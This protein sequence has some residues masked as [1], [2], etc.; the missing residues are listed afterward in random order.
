MSTVCCQDGACH[1][2]KRSAILCAHFVPS[3]CFTLRMY[4]LLDSQQRNKNNKCRQNFS[5]EKKYVPT[6]YYGA[7]S[8][9]RVSSNLPLKRNPFLFFRIRSM[10]IGHTYH[11][12]LIGA[13]IMFLALTVLLKCLFFV[14]EKTSN[15]CYW[16]FKFVQN[17]I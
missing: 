16:G 14:L 3:I 9:L 11:A 13:A 12:G 4:K 1:R 6:A 8:C 7:I 15:N 10:F 17:K 5:D 2:S